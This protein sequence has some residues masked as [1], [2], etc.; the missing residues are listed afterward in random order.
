[1]EMKEGEGGRKERERAKENQKR[2]EKKKNQTDND[3]QQQQ[4]FKGSAKTFSFIS[5]ILINCFFAR[6]ILLF[7]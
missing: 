1:M 7:L 6:W 5:F 2:E 4:T 3:K